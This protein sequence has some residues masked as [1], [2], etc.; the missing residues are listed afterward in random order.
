MDERERVAQSSVWP[1]IAVAEYASASYPKRVVYLMNG[2]CLIL[3]T[4]ACAGSADSDVGQPRWDADGDGISTAVETW[5]ANSRYNFD[6][7]HADPNPSTSYGFP[8]NG[9]LTNGINFPDTDPGV[10]VYE[11]RPNPVG[12]GGY[13]SRYDVPDSNDWGTLKLIN[14]IEATGRKWVDQNPPTDVCYFY[15]LQNDSSF[16]AAHFGVGDMSKFGGGEWLHSY[17]G[18][19]RH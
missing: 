16:A 12:S 2:L 6:T 14:L 10:G 9:T 15:E 13:D 3:V 19:P 4:S 1:L 8:W 17:D 7:T 18:T 5:P 11:F